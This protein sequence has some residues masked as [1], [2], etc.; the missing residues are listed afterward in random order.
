MF[1]LY[2]TSDLLLHLQPFKFKIITLSIHWGYNITKSVYRQ[3]LR[4]E[5]TDTTCIWV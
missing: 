2:K 1:L 4:N 5:S 3:S